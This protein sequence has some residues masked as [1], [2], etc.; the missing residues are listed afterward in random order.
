MTEN[1]T[2]PRNT[3]GGDTRVYVTQL[4]L[5]NASSCEMVHT[6]AKHELVA[7]RQ[8]CASYVRMRVMN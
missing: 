5:D 3:L 7:C 4:D 6:V 8:H 2:P 1:Q